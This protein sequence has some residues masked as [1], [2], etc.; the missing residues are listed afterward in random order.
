MVLFLIPLCSLIVAAPEL[1]VGILVQD[2]R[3]LLSRSAPFAVYGQYRQRL[4]TSR[5][6]I[7][8]QISDSWLREYQGYFQTFCNNAPSRVE[9]IF[10]ELSCVK[11]SSHFLLFF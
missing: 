8:L 9:S 3:P 1:E 10:H 4:Q 5:M 7:V 11:P 6:A 2:L